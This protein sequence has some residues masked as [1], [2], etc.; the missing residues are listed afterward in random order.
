MGGSQTRPYGSD[1]IECEHKMPPKKSYLTNAPLAA[2]RLRLR[3]A[4]LNWFR[5]NA[6]DLPWRWSRDIYAVW[7]SEIMLQQTRVET[8]VPYFERFMRRFPTVKHLALAREDELLRVWQGLGYY[9]R[10]RNLQRA[11]QII[12]DERNGAFP[13]TVEEW[14]QIPGVGRYTAGAIA[15]I[16]L[17]IRAP[18]LD[19]NVKRVLA[20]LFSI[21]DALENAQVRKRLWEMA[22]DLVPPKYPGD[23]NQAMMELGARICTPKRPLCT[24]CPVRKVCEALEQG[25][26]EELPTRTQ[27]KKIPHYEVVAAVI[28]KNGRYLLGKRPSGGMLGGLWEFPGGKVERGENHEQALIRELREEMG[29]EIEVG[30][31]L[32]M[33]E[34]TYS[35]FRITLHVYECRH[36]AG[37]PRPEYH[38]EIKWI[39]PSRLEDYPLPAADLKF[40]DLL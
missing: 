10:A 17:G 18:V 23:F 9:T 14:S 6:R 26:V 34:H 33:V 28:R 12:F 29:I 35:H 4:L 21:R 3:R 5:K 2:K 30:P 20:R 8:V 38:Q 19:G 24:E 11:A 31:Y 15:S 36:R 37:T 40:L 7:V 16:A 13:Q 27:R 39:L 25:Y 1:R 22:G 32:V